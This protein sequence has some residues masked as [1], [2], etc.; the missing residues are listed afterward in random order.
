MAARAS[1]LAASL[2]PPA[3][4]D[5]PAPRL[6]DASL[7]PEQLDAAYRQ[8]CLHTRALFH[9]CRL[10]HGDLSEYNLLWH[11][12]RVVFIDVSQSVE[13]DHPSALDFLRIDCKNLTGAPR[14]CASAPRRPRPGRSPEAAHVGADFFR[15]SGV[16]VLPTPA[17][18]GF[19][20]DPSLPAAAEAVSA[21]FEAL[22]ARAGEQGLAQS[23]EQ[24][25]EESVFM[26]TYIPRSLMEVRERRA[27]GAGQ[28]AVGS[29]G[30]AAGARRTP[31]HGQCLVTVIRMTRPCL[32]PPPPPP[33]PPPPR[34][35]MRS[36][37]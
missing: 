19:I 12:G 29:W 13:H 1:R 33:P 27:A 32:H 17:L 11:K 21:E 30:W 22:V 34:A 24:A 26:Q 4:R 37:P 9:Q 5:R 36:A 14:L 16:R 23:S 25:V 20:C 3:S 10:V 35:T 2:R 15:K 8:V 18:F 28:R 7:S 6:K 31:R